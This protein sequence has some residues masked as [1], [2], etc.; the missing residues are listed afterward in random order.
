MKIVTITI[1]SLVM[2]LSTTAIGQDIYTG[3]LME[4]DKETPVIP[5]DIVGKKFVENLDFKVSLKEFA[6]KPQDQGL[7]PSCVGWSV[8]YGALTIMEA[9]RK[10]WVNKNLV[11]QEAFSPLFIYNQLAINKDCEYAGASFPS[12]FRFLKAQGTCKKTAFNVDNEDC[13]ALPNNIIKRSAFDNRIKDYYQLFVKDSPTKEKINKTRVSLSEGFPVVVGMYLTPDFRDVSEKEPTWRPQE[14]HDDELYPHA[15]VVV[16]YDDLTKTFEIMNSWGTDWGNKGFVNVT[17]RDFAKYCVLAYQV[18]LPDEGEEVLASTTS[19]EPID[20]FAPFVEEE[21]MKEGNKKKK[22]PAE[23]ELY[24]DFTFRYPMLDDDGYPVYDENNEV[25]FKSADVEL[26]DNH[27]YS[28][29]KKD[30]EIGQL[31]Q[32]SANNIKKNRYVYVFSLDSENNMHQHWPR[33]KMLTNK[34]TRA[35]AEDTYFGYTEA[36][37][38]PYN[39]AQIVIPKSG[40]ALRKDTEGDDYLFVLYSYEVIE[41]IDY[42][43]EKVRMSTL[44]YKDRLEEALGERLI[45]YE[46]VKFKTNKVSGKSKTANGTV[47]GIMIESKGW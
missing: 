40:S 33:T 10:D 43:E 45:P 18:H 46:E 8:G 2:L 39:N 29:T 27:Y 1:F 21:T 19:S 5:K 13:S 35:K 28:L 25:K 7:L 6:P 23:V 24:G 30:W 16:G 15:M 4:E 47:L 34:D 9:Q 41:D 37:L 17:Y 36:P 22:L 31:F 11:T 38:V 42:I 44:P 32:L 26:I 14:T 12:A 20:P 3:L